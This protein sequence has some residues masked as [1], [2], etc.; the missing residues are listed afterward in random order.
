LVCIKIRKRIRKG[1]TKILKRK[2]K[3]TIEMIRKLNIEFEIPFEALIN[4]YEL[5]G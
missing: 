5:S 1:V 4:D 3:L 2:R